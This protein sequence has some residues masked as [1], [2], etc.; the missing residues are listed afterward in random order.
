MDFRKLFWRMYKYQSLEFCPKPW[1]KSK[2]EFLQ[3]NLIEIGEYTLKIHNVPQFYNLCWGWYS[4]W[5]WK[6][7]FT[8]ARLWYC[9]EVFLFPNFF[10]Y[11]IISVS[12]VISLYLLGFN[13]S[14]LMAGAAAFACRFRIWIAKPLQ[15]FYSGVVLLLMAHWR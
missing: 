12:L 11:I 13:V 4:C 2:K 5:L 8:K 10:R 1:K 6:T 9:K 15:W 14:V 3:S 7:S